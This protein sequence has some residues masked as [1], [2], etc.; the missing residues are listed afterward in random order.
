MSPTASTIVAKRQ[1]TVLQHAALGTPSTL[2]PM[3]KREEKWTYD[4][5]T[6]LEVVDGLHK[7][8]VFAP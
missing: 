4:E 3:R 7:S 1:Y 6:L 2:S 8:S 5:Q